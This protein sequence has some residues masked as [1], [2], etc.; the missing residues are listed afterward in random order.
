MVE[1]NAMILSGEVEQHSALSW[2]VR[3]EYGNADCNMFAREDR[4][5]SSF[6]SAFGRIHNRFVS[7][8][9]VEKLN[10]ISAMTL[11]IPAQHNTKFLS[12]CKI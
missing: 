3:I 11:K 7:I 10:S 1:T 8:F 4:C 6:S 9:Y 5:Q 12:F 2:F